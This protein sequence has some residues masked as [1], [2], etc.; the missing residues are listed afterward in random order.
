VV[1]VLDD[2]GEVLRTRTTPDF[3]A[4]IGRAFAEIPVRDADRTPVGWT[5][6]TGQTLML[7]SLDEIAARF[8]L[9]AHTHEATGT[10]ECG[11]VTYLEGGRSAALG[12]CDAPQQASVT[13]KPGARLVLYTDGLIERRAEPIDVGFERLAAA[14]GQNLDLDI[15][16]WCQS[17]L[18]ALTQ[19]ETLADDVALACIELRDLP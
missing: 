4:D 1:A 7:A 15:G 10:S 17:L 11:S 9:A 19:G 16:A 3:P 6:R 2:T 18:T 12:F 13:V 5:V 8:P 14:A